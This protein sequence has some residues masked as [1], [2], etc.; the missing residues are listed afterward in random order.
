VSNGLP[1]G[2]PKVQDNSGGRSIT[3]ANGETIAV[4]ESTGANFRA[5]PRGAVGVMFRP[6]VWDPTP[7]T[8]VRIAKLENIVW[9]ALY[10]LALIGLWACRRRRDVIAY[11]FI[12]TCA[13]LGIAALTEGNAGT[14]F[15]HRGQV[16]WAIAI[17]ALMGLHHVRTRRRQA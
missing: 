6:F 12:V 9:Y 8:S 4:D 7:N 1:S 3:G 11:P 5:L 15:R 2:G 17:F 13:I 14:A 10:G 16:L